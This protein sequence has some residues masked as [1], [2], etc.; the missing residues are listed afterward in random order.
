VDT[1]A[2]VVDTRAKVAVTRAR[3]ADTRAKV[4]ALQ[5][6]VAIRE[7]T[8]VLLEPAIREITHVLLEPAIREPIPVLPVLVTKGQIPGLKAL[9]TRAT[10][11]VQPVLL[12]I[13]LVRVVTN[14]VQAAVVGHPVVSDPKVAVRVVDLPSIVRVA[15]VQ[16]QVVRPVVVDKTLN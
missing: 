14:H 9:A 12:A 1:R 4:A 11:L 8:H 2:R 13:S 15:A 16:D 3:V 6:P 7:I 10:T 5:E